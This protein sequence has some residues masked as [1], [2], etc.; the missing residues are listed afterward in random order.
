LTISDGKA[1]TSTTYTLQHINDPG[2]VGLVQRV[3]EGPQLFGNFLALDAQGKTLAKDEFI[4][5]DGTVPAGWKYVTGGPDPIKPGYASRIDAIGWHPVDEPNAAYFAAAREFQRQCQLLGFEGRFFATEI[6]SASMYPPTPPMWGYVSG[7][8]T[9]MAKYFVKSL[10]GHSGVGME[11]GPCHPHFTAFAHPQ[12]LC[13]TT[14]G[15]QT[16][17][18]CRPTMTYYMWRTLATALDDFQPRNFP[19]RFSAEKGLAF[20]TFQRGDERMV[21]VWMDGP[22]KDGMAQTKLNLTFPEVRATKATVVDI[23]N[24]TEQE[25]NFSSDSGDTVLK[26]MLIKDYP[27][28]IT[29]SR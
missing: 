26:G 13:Q 19:V 7:S 12:A 10:V 8:E 9:Q 5:A 17:H 22:E 20:F 14:W 1:S 29:I 15:M 24:G 6:Y 23:M 3:A 4:G 25:L 28:L 2:M 11:A 18:P 27:V 21:G 16:L